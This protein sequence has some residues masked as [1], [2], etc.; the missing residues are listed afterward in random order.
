MELKKS[1]I[2]E[3]T[4]GENV[5]TFMIPW[6]APLG[7]AYDASFEAMQYVRKLLNDAGDKAQRERDSEREQDNKSDEEQ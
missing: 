7:E 5:Y 4:K 2:V 1:H 3:V 6:S